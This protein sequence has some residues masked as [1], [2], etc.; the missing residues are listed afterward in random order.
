MRLSDRIVLGG[1]EKGGWVRLGKLVVQ[2]R[3]GPRHFLSGCGPENFRWCGFTALW[4]GTPNSRAG[5]HVGFQF[6][7]GFSFLSL[8]SRM[9]L[10]RQSPYHFRTRPSAEGDL[11]QLVDSVDGSGVGS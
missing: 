8:L 7:V 6:H 10:L 9:Q 4:L 1:D 11:W 2:K 5:F 3:V